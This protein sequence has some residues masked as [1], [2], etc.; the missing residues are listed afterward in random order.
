VA[1]AAALARRRGRGPPGA[2]RNGRDGLG[3]G[4]ADRPLQ[5]QVVPKERIIYGPAPAH[6]AP[7]LPGASPPLYME[8][9]TPEPGIAMSLDDAQRAAGFHVLRSV[10]EPQT[11]LLSALYY[12]PIARTDEHPTGNPSA[13]VQVIYRF[14]TLKLSVL[15]KPNPNPGQPLQIVQLGADP[16]SRLEQHAGAEYLVTR[17]PDEQRVQGVQ[18]ATESTFAVMHFSSPFA[19]WPAAADFIAHLQ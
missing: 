9:G 18:F 15:Q 5:V 1:P 3:G 11:Q 12:P 8:A 16:H 6:P 13:G 10:G 14:G 2:G 19:D 17:T 4:P 7:L